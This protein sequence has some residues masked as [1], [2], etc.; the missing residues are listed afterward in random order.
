MTTTKSQAIEAL[1]EA[2]EEN[3]LISLWN[4]FLEDEARYDDSIYNMEDFEEIT[5]GWKPLEA[6]SRAFYGDFNPN[7]NYFAFN[8]YG[9]LV[10]FDYVDDENCPICAYDMV[11]WFD[12]NKD[13][14]MEEYNIDDEE[15]IF[16]NN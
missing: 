2:Q 16:D 14:L 11:Y 8:G 7:D 9:N 10:S 6:I 3:V 4:R 1:I 13:D 12:E 5:S 15:G